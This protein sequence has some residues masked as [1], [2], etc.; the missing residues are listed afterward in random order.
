[1]SSVQEW[2]MFFV[3]LW[4]LLWHPPSGTIADQDPRPKRPLLQKL[5][6]A[7]LSHNVRQ[8]SGRSK[9]FKH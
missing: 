5:D 1:M 6:Q 2:F 9:S 7:E 3:L 4:F 8:T